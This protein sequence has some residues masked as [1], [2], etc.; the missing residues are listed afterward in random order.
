MRS[1]G[2]AQFSLDLRADRA[3]ALTV[4]GQSVAVVGLTLRH[5][6][7]SMPQLVLEMAGEGTIEGEGI[8]AVDQ[9]GAGD[10]IEYLRSFLANLDPGVLEKA[11]IEQFDIGA[12]TN[13][14]AFLSALIAMVGQ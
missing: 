5:V 11:A 6:P 14:Q 7:P 9:G 10:E 3:P 4:N 8:V 13:G 12:E 1:M 2:L